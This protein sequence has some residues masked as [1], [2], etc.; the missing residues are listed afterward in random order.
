MSTSSWTASATQTLR[1]LREA[2]SR[3][4]RICILGIGNELNGDDACGLWAARK[5]LD[6]QRQ[7]WDKEKESHRSQVEPAAV[8][9]LETGPAPENFTADIRRFAPDLVILIDAA[10]MGEAPGAVRWLDWRET[11][12]LPGSTHS[13][14]LHMLSSYL[15]AELGCQVALLGIQPKGNELG[16]GLSNEGERAVEE[17]VQGLLDLLTTQAS[18]I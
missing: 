7:Q 17:V 4:L 13:L 6:K 3:T 14:P 5:L 2:K 10:Q 15:Y 1:Q 11:I 18:S 16:E 9:V 8:L 12:G